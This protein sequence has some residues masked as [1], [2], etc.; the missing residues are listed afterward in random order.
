[1]DTRFFTYSFRFSIV[2]SCYGFTRGFRIQRA[3]RSSRET[4]TG[5]LPSFLFGERIM[6]GFGVACLSFLPGWNVWMLLR[7]CNRLEIYHKLWDPTQ[8]LSEYKEGIG[9]CMNT[10]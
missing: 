1:M 6:N 10:V 3:P 7:L 2:M 5:A 9:Y 8:Y 4:E